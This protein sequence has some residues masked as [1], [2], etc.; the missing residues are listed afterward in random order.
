MHERLE[1]FAKVPNDV[2]LNW[3]VL[4]VVLHWQWPELVV[5]WWQRVL[6]A[7][8][9]VLGVLFHAGSMACRFVCKFISRDTCVSF[10]LLEV[11]WAMQN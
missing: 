4:I 3:C 1:A 5:G 2:L 10:Y 9:H 11:Y 7:S 6:D 8:R